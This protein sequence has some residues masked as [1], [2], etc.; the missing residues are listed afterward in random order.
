MAT[1]TKKSITKHFL[2]KHTLELNDKM[3]EEEYEVKCCVCK[4]GISD[5]HHYR[6]SVGCHRTRIHEY[7][8]YEIPFQRDHHPLH[9]HHS[10]LFASSGSFYPGS[11]DFCGKSC[12]RKFS[13]R[14]RSGKRI[15]LIP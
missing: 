1:T 3:E 11:C 2:H 9:P 14:S 8:C 12:R 7:P 6:C 15:T 13:F 10:P 4:Q 5:W